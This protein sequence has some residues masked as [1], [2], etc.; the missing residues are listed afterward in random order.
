MSPGLSPSRCLGDLP[1]I[2][3]ATFTARFAEQRAPIVITDV[4]NE[5]PARERWTHAYLMAKLGLAST[6]HGVALDAE[7]RADIALPSVARNPTPPNVWLLP[8]GYVSELHFDLP[9]NLNT[10]LSGEKDFVLFA[11]TEGKNLYPGSIFGD[12]PQNSRIRLDDVAP[13]FR[14][15]ARAR[16]WKTTLVPGETIYVPPCF[17]HFVRSRGESIAANVWFDPERW[18]IQ[19]IARWPRG[20]IARA[21]I[22]KLRRLISSRGSVPRRPRT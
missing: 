18:R 13:R 12:G 7:L 2:D 1:R 10:V 5:W 6:G 8:D 19:R 4:A 16:W 22:D 15:V 20:V 17:W 9:H 14:R 21:A 11:P 3:L